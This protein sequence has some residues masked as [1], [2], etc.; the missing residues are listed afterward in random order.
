MPIILDILLEM[1]SIWLDVSFCL[2]D[3]HEDYSE[4]GGSDNLRTTHKEQPVS[5]YTYTQCKQS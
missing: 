2:K 3:G 5:P 4:Q 1:L